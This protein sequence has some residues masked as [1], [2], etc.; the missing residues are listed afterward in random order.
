MMKKYAEEYIENGWSLCDV[1]PGTKIAAG[2]A[3][4][5]KGISADKCINNIGLIHRLSGTCAID[6][7]NLE[8]ARTALEAIGVDMDAL[9]AEGVQISSGRDNRAKLLYNAPPDL[10]AKRHALSWPDVGC[11]IE[12][13]AG[14]TQDLL[15]P[16]IH[17]DTGKP[18][19]WIG[20]WKNL[21]DLSFNLLKAWQTWDIAKD[22]MEDACPWAKQDTSRIP[23]GVKPKAYKDDH[24]NGGVIGKFNQNYEPGNILEAN[25]YKKA[26]NRW[27]CP[28]STSG[29]PGV[30]MLPD[31][32][33]ARIY[34]HHGSDPLADGHSHDAFSV[35]CQVEHSGNIAAAVSNAA[36]LLGIER[37]PLP[38]DEQ[39]QRMV[40]GIM[41][42]KVEKLSDHVK[43]KEERK[44]ETIEAP[45]PGP[46]PI[47][48]LRDAEQ[49]IASS[50]HTVKKDALIQSVLAF[51]CS[52]TSRR[53]VTHDGQPATAYLGVTDSSLSG[54]RLL[55]NPV[56]TLCAKLGERTALHT[57]DISTRQAV[58]RH[59][60]RHPRLF[61]VTDTYGTLVQGTKRQTNGAYE[62]VLSALQKCYSGD[63]QYLDPEAAGVIGQKMRSIS[64]CDIHSPSITI[65][66]FI[67][68]AH[69]D[70]M[71]SRNEYG[72]GTLHDMAI[73]PGGDVMQ[74]HH[75]ERGKPIP[76]SVTALVKAL[77]DVKGMAGAEQNCGLEPSVTVIEWEKST[78]SKMV[79]EWRD[80][81]YAYMDVNAR[82]QY[83]GFVYGYRETAIRLAA[84][85]AA[86]E[87][88]EYSVV[89]PKIMQWCLTWCERC[90]RLTM[91]RLEVS[92]RDAE[93]KPD[94]MQLVLEV[95]MN[96]KAPLTRREIARKCFAFKKLY[97]E[98]K[99]AM[100]NALIEGGGIVV[101][102]KGKVK[103]Y[104]TCAN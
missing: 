49:W 51:A 89:T 57:G 7:D 55:T 16:S 87:S 41:G 103:K 46:L 13:R 40:D 68:E 84:C 25:S 34:S 79:R 5:E 21:P 97:D 23:S 14:D 71:A 95:L 50:I 35:F 29:I 69:L 17:P 102:K 77:A 2:K 18:Y 58:Y 72:R 45:H 33:P 93:G 12:F 10:P 86:W 38:L 53:Y 83:K 64:E 98:E 101:S 27:R 26:G 61:W 60:F 43:Q 22:A 11:V 4:P 63:T 99:E 30:I 37:E 88:P 104:L 8:H 100:L 6:I 44:P 54:I 73:I 96:S 59:L 85:L 91:P 75:P 9:L 82:S 20:D 94:T 47:G 90:L 1:L 3:W 24:V 31:S 66:A 67:S 56:A 19:E 92:S 76:E 65:L 32:K 70:S 80:K 62:G 74:G 28:N 48:A 42:K 36:K 78:V 15:P 39:S 81:M 52:V